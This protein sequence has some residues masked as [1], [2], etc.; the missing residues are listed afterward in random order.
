MKW[1]P[2]KDDG[3]SPVTGYV[4][5]VKD[6]YGNWEKAVTVPAGQTRATVP[7]LTEGEPYVFQ[8]RAINAAGPG[9][10]SDPTPT[11][12]AKPRNQAP[13][14]DRTN[15]IEVTTLF[16]FEMMVFSDHII[17]WTKKF[18]SISSP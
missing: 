15:L 4:V 2:P 12:W 5:E 9:E 7:G 14:I 8:V 16:V 3:G 13:K 17:V 1:D 11:I 18:N 10:A 6:K